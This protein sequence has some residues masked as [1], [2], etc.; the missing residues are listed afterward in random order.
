[1]SSYRF[2][3]ISLIS[4]VL[5][6]SAGFAAQTGAE[7]IFSEVWNTYPLQKD[8]GPDIPALHKR[9]MSDTYQKNSE[10]RILVKV[11]ESFKKF[12]FIQ[13]RSSYFKNK[14][15][16]SVC[17]VVLIFNRELKSSEVQN[18]MDVFNSA[19]QEAAENVKGESIVLVTGGENDLSPLALLAYIGNVQ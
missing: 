15:S 19:A 8:D 6:S 4:M 2:C 14:C 3:A 9:A 17:E 1:M 5:V 13:S 11:T 10:N 12:G 16:D 7:S 18:K